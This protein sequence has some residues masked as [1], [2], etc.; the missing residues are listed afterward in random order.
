MISHKNLRNYYD[1]GFKN[2]AGWCSEKNFDV[3]EILDNVEIN[4][5]GGCM[6]IGIHHGKFFIMLN[7]LVDE[8]YPSFAIDV[9]DDQ[10]LNIDRS[11]KGN[12]DAFK[13]NLINHDRHNGSN[14]KI[15]KG[16][17]TDPSL[18]LRDTIGL[19]TMRFISIDGGHTAEH[20]VSDLILANDLVN[21]QGIVI[22][23]DILNYHWLGVIEGTAKFIS[24]HPT[25]VPFAIGYNK[26]YMCKLSFKEFYYKTFEESAL[27]TKLVNFFGHSIVAL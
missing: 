3:M 1:N 25:L 4:K 18:R 12:L 21:N 8:K 9:F 27:K 15:I 14:V 17:S 7:C 16:D 20:T 24:F 22:L 10:S 2:T 6:E 13:T 26:L 19:G 23:D 5:N 11:G